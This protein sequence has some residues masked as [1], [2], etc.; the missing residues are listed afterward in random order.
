MASN[1]DD[2]VA[3]SKL[4]SKDAVLVD[5][6][7]PFEWRGTSAG[8]AWWRAVE[9]FMIK[10]RHHIRLVNVRIS[11]FQ[12]SAVDA[13]L[14]QPMTIMEIAGGREPSSESGTLTYTF[15]QI[16]GTWLIISQVWTTKP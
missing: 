1:T 16:D 10:E 7:P 4:Y 14:I 11:E 15:R 2:A 5:E 3:F 13:Y 12:R 9:A 8:I 6:I